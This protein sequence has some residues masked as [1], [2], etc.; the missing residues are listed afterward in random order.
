MPWG[1]GQRR[2][3]PGLGGTRK[4]R[5]GLSQELVFLGQDREGEDRWTTRELYELEQNILDVATK[6]EKQPSWVQKQATEAA[7]RSRPTLNPDQAEA[8]RHLCLS[9]GQVKCVLGGAGVGKTFAADCAREAIEASG[10]RVIG[11]SL[12]TRATRE[13]ANQGHIRQCYNVRKLIYELDRG[14][15]KFDSRTFLFMD[16]AAMTGTRDFARILSEVVRSGATLACIGDYRQHQSIEAGGV[17]LGL[18]KRHAPAELETI[19]R[20]RDPED[21]RMVAAFRDQKIAEA[22]ESLVRR[23]RLLIGEEVSDAQEL[24]VQKWGE[25]LAAVSDKLFIASTNLQVKSLNERCQKLRAERGELLGDGIAIKGGARAFIGDRVLLRQNAPMLGIANGDFGTVLKVD[26]EARELRLRL[27]DG[28]RIV[29]V[30]LEHYDR[31]KVTLGYAS[32][33]HSAQGG[34]SRTSICSSTAR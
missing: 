27:D 29:T 3:A 8:V 18:S 34:V 20:Q 7:I 31:E 33:S 9:P 15:L 23:E 6:A 25:D 12:S 11:T 19:I 14:R 30:S 4:S 17:F 5:R 2:S 21:R 24:A 10:G 13:L 22:L 16:E 26:S 1:Q 32:T 28:G